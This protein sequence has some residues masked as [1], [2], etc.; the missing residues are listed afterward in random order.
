MPMLVI[1]HTHRKNDRRVPDRREQFHTS[2][3][4]GSSFGRASA[5]EMSGFKN[6]AQINSESAE[7]HDAITRN[8][9]RAHLAI[10][11][12]HDQFHGVKIN[13]LEFLRKLARLRSWHSARIRHV[14][15]VANDSEARRCLLDKARGQWQSFTE[16]SNHILTSIGA[17]LF[18]F[19][20]AYEQSLPIERLAWLQGCWES[21]SS[22]RTVE[23]QW[24]AP[25]GGIMLG[26]GRTVRGSTLVE[27]EMVII[28]EQGNQLAYEAHPSGQPSAVFLSGTVSDSMIVFE[29]PTH[30]FPQ[31]IGYQRTAPDVLLAWIEGTERGKERR[32]EFPYRR[33]TCGK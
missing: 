5:I 18:L 1:I 24:M 27:Y 25:R 22:Q 11:F 31:R 12:D 32:I 16:R 33:T 21:S 10:G 17:L 14:V 30:D 3:R 2:K 29:N 8:P 9:A 28:R 15:R 13:D 6:A 26:M 4:N 23:E 7:F 19:F 20:F